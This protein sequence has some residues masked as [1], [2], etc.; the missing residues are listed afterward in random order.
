MR[1]IPD[2]KLGYSHIL[3][4][5]K[6]YLLAG[7]ASVFSA[8]VSRVTFSLSPSLYPTPGVR[9]NRLGTGMTKR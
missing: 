3:V 5:V 4:T 9:G 2:S 6:R 1:I 7:A 8:V